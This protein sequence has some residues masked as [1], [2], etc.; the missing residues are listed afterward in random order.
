[1]KR[2]LRFASF[3]LLFGFVLVLGTKTADAHTLY[4]VQKGDTLSSVASKHHT[5]EATIRQD[6]QMLNI[7]AGDWIAVNSS[8]TVRKGETLYHVAIQH[9]VTIEQLKKWNHLKSTT[10]HTGQFLLLREPTHKKTDSD[11]FVTPTGKC[12]VISK[13]IHQTEQYVPEYITVQKGDT[14]KQ[15]AT[16]FATTVQQ[17]KQWNHLSSEKITAGQK[18]K[19]IDY[20]IFIEDTKAV[21]S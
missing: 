1:M 17:L 12:I 8:Y 5:N 18:I 7:K 11:V 13:D 15:L 19:V 16:D 2:I 3:L 9:N 20:S 21:L 10:I 4:Q 6:N 14:L